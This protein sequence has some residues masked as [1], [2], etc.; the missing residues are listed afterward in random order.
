[1]TMFVLSLF[2]LTLAAGALTLSLWLLRREPGPVEA[3][4]ALPRLTRSAEFYRPMERLF[5]SRDMAFL[6]DQAGFRPAMSRRLRL[7]RRRV[8][9]LYLREV[10]SDFMALEEA[11]RS[12]ARR[13]HNWELVSLIYRQRVV[14]HGLLLA[15][16]VRC[17]LESVIFVP[18]DTGGLL[19]T[20]TDL[21]RDLR[22]FADS[23]D[24]RAAT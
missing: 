8:L 6:R 22:A 3:S 13:S 2:V 7:E 17:Q 11:C 15:L 12:M 4:E 24:A 16:R 14:F 9:A 18:V 20:L 23:M 21:E 1:M 5:T 10:R 19:A